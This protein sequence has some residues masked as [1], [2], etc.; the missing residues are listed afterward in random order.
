MQGFKL[1][2]HYPQPPTANLSWEHVR[3]QSKSLQ[4]SM[5]T[6]YRKI[7]LMKQQL[8]QSNTSRSKLYLTGSCMIEK[9][10]AWNKNVSVVRFHYH[11]FIR[12]YRCFQMFPSPF[13][14]QEGNQVGCWSANGEWKEGSHWADCSNIDGYIVLSLAVP[15]ESTL[16]KDLAV[17]SAHGKGHYEFVQSEQVWQRNCRTNYL[18]SFLSTPH[19]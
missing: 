18:P 2:L 5:Q 13:T 4:P 10:T 3:L 16:G 9:I 19:S 1:H 17:L 15:L 8:W 11:S 12:Q 7:S 6:S 14:P